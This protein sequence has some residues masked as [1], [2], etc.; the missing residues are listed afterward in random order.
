MKQIEHCTLIGIAG[1]SGSGKTTFSHQLARSLEKLKVKIISTDNYFKKVKQQV[2]APYNGRIYDDYDHP[3]SVD[4]EKLTGDIKDSVLSNMFD[5][6]V[7][8]GLMVLYFKEIREMFDLKI[9]I[10]CP[11]DERLVRRLKRDLNEETFENISAEYLDLVRH[12]YNEFVEPTKWYADVI[13]NGSNPSQKS[14][15]VVRKW[16]LK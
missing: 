3:S 14:L 16:V 1:G 9:F 10:D 15:D 8:E 11:S 4:I 7:V 6:V 5:I 13:L 2:K 12:R